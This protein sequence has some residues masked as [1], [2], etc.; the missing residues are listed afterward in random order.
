[1]G[2]LAADS[3][4]PGQGGGLPWASEEHRERTS[5]GATCAVGAESAGHSG[6]GYCAGR[7]QE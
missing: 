6:C 3:R 4:G 1:M 7:K 2:P 5:N